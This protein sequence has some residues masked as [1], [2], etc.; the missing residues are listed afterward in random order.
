MA[1][2]DQN[3]YIDLLF[4]H[5][6]LRCY[7]VIELKASNF[8]P[9]YV[10]KP[11]FYMTAVDEQL[12]RPEDNPTIGLVL[13]KTNNNKSVA[14]YALKSV[15]SPIGIAT[16][17]SKAALPEPFKDQLPDIKELEESLEEIKTEAD[18]D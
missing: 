3:F 1:V 4:Y 6:R 16:Y 14:E 12:K 17:Q 5:T 11:G 13:C 10:G 7:V 8:K 9:E 18:Q 15:H 2:G